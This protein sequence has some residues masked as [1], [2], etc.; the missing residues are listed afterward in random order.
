MKYFKFLILFLL[1]FL[2]IACEQDSGKKALLPSPVFEEKP[3]TPL[4]ELIK[5]VQN[6]V[7]MEPLR[8]LEN[9]GFY[10]TKQNLMRALENS[11]QKEVFFSCNDFKK[12]L[13]TTLQTEY[14]SD[15][16]AG[17]W[18]RTEVEKISQTIAKEQCADIHNLGALLLADLQRV[19]N[20]SNSQEEFKENAKPV[21]EE[22]ASN[23]L[24]KSDYYVDVLNKIL[25][26]YKKV[27][28]AF[29]PLDQAGYGTYI[30]E[31]NDF[32]EVKKLVIPVIQGKV[33]TINEEG[34]D[35]IV[36]AAQEEEKILF[37]FL[38]QYD[39]LMQ[40]QSE[41]IRAFYPGLKEKWYDF[42]YEIEKMQADKR[43]EYADKRFKQAKEGLQS[44]CPDLFIKA[45]TKPKNNMPQM[46]P[47]MQGADNATKSSA[48]QPGITNAIKNNAAANVKSN[49]AN[50]ANTAEEDIEDFG[51]DEEEA[52]YF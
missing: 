37:V 26:P 23:V 19:A 41:C 51:E 47:N 38:K 11:T 14:S 50:T 45:N 28:Q 16:V 32:K 46:Q 35:K 13:L 40:T 52:Y 24:G 10:N 43:Q 5:K 2:F 9:S 18:Q 21:I 17:S 31:Q 20:A 30:L 1:S 6:T 29:Y 4:E 42:M 15:F 22:Y 39:S 25:V 34:V 36:A 27:R 48:N 49:T 3:K 44:K 7:I 33:Q 8:A 12:L